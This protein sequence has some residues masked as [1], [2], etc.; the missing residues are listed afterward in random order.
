MS[1]DT[2]MDVG[3]GG[4]ALLMVYSLRAMVHSMRDLV[5]N[6]KGLLEHLTKRVDNH[7][8]RLDALE[9]VPDPVTV[10]GFR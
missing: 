7:D 5:D 8:D 9:A 3:M 1:L 2:I 10:G 4:T 6:M